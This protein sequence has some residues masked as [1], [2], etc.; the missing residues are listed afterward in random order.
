MM[1]MKVKQLER[2]LRRRGRELILD[3]ELKFSGW[4]L[5]RKVKLLTKLRLRR[6]KVESRLVHL[7]DI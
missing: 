1:I 5:V 2:E 4:L 7:S 6:T 3:Q